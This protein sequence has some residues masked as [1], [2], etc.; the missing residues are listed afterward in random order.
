[1]CNFKLNG[2]SYRSVQQP[3]EKKLKQKLSFRLLGGKE[4]VKKNY[5]QHMLIYF[6]FIEN[7]SNEGRWIILQ[8]QRIGRVKAIL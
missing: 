1:M 6:F 2:K 3:I 4:N 7:S 8:L 5:R